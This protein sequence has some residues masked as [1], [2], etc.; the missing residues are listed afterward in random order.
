MLFVLS[1]AV[2]VL[3]RLESN[4]VIA[5]ISKDMANIKKLSDEL[6]RLNRIKNKS[7]IT[8]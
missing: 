3:E 8:K 5:Y 4:G 7:I 2:D 1:K 6:D